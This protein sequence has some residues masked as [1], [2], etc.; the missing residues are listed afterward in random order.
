MHILEKGSRGAGDHSLAAV[1][2]NTSMIN[3]LVNVFMGLS[4]GAN[5]L[6]A[7]YFAGKQQEELRKTVHTA[8]TISVLSGIFLAVIGF[9]AARQLL[10]WMQS[11]TEVID[12]ATVI[13]QIISAVLV[14][15]CLMKEEGAVR[16]FFGFGFF[17]K[18]YIF[19]CYRVL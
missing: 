16:L 19:T 2:S 4:V 3:L 6:V 17:C 1:G 10:I 7:R 12:L 14:L 9:A 15:K 8:I 5:V 13:S 11:P 18:L